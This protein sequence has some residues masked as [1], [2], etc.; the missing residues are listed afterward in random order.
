MLYIHN[1]IIMYK[2]YLTDRKGVHGTQIIIVLNRRCVRCRE[3]L[4]SCRNGVIC[5]VDRTV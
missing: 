3:L 2:A 4:M 5:S 1:Y